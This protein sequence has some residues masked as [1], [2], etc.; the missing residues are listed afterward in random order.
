LLLLFMKPKNW[1]K[2]TKKIKKQIENFKTLSWKM[3][4]LRCVSLARTRRYV[5]N[6]FIE[7]KIP[8]PPLMHYECIIV[9]YNY[10]TWKFCIQKKIIHHASTTKYILAR[11]GRIFHSK[12]STFFLDTAPRRTLHWCW[13]PSINFSIRQHH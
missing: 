4:F 2:K 12:K 3:S 8:S 1:L 13:D 5:V 10:F 6:L 9:M 11:L 7:K